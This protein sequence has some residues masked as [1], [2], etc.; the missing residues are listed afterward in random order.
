MTRVFI[1]Y[2][3]EDSYF[4][5]FLAELLKFHHV[6]VWVDQSD[7]RAGSEFPSCI[8]NALAECDVMAV[9]ISQHS[10]QSQWMVREISRFKAVNADR[11]VIPLLLDNTT[12]PN[13]LYEGLGQVVQIRFYRSILEG[14][15][16][17]LQLLDRTLLPV[18]ENR[19]VPDR[20]A[21]DRRKRSDRRNPLRRLRMSMYDYV[22]ITHN[23]LLKPMDSWTEVSQLVRDLVAENS[24]LHS[25]DFMDKESGN[26]VHLDSSWIERAA[27]DS[28]RK[29]GDKDAGWGIATRR[30][31]S[32]ITCAAYIVDEIMGKIMAVYIVKQADRRSGQRRNRVQ[33]R[34]DHA[35]SAWETVFRMRLH[36]AIRTWAGQGSPMVAAW[37][38]SSESGGTRS[39]PSGSFRYP[40]AV[41]DFPV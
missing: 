27:L 21:E 16:T 34:K 1:S 6:N 39:T 32:E 17:L 10:S 14:F 28:L 8:D 15:R 36:L 30:Q 4:V 5:D 24:P 33:R 41:P 35:L 26:E 37:M 29:K 13:K 19:A 9:V 18:V 20:R 11:P 40:A 2:C 38:N 7:I 23:D 22:E 3:S 12:D 25:F 31:S